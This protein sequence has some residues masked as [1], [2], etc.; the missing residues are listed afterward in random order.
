MFNYFHLNIPTNLEMDPAVLKIGIIGDCGVGKST[1]ARR[2]SSCD[3]IHSTTYSPTVGC[4][5]YVRSVDRNRD[6]P[7]RSR[8]QN[9]PTTSPHTPLSGPPRSH[10]SSY[11][12]NLNP[13]GSF[14]VEL[15]DIGGNPRYACARSVYFEG[16]Q[17]FIFVWDCSD[18]G[19]YHGL[20]DW[21][22]DIRVSAKDYASL[23]CYCT[24]TVSE[25]QEKSRGQLQGICRRSSTYDCWEQGRQGQR[26]GTQSSRI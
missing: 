23:S 5:S 17:G 16:L 21:I 22:E 1:L 7:P 3:E 12:S 9:L 4:V 2:L 26:S 11:S 8:A 24:C 19:S 20:D 25:I 10:Q 6:R 13:E 15:F 14:V 18:E